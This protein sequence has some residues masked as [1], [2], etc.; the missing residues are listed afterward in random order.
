VLVASRWSKVVRSEH[1]RWLHEDP[2]YRLRF[3]AADMR[4]TQTLKDE[5]VRRAHDGVVKLVL[6]KGQPVFFRGEPIVEHEYSDHL[7]IKL[8]EAGDPD[9]F[10]RQKV[11]PFDENFDYDKMTEGQVRACSNG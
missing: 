8:L 1:Y 3:E 9:H 11:A 5:A 6:Y 7:L 2:S 10:N 4:Y